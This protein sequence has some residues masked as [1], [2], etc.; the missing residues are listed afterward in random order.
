MERVMR[1]IEVK[2]SVDINKHASNEEIQRWLEFELNA[3]GNLSR[4]NPLIDEAIEA[5]SFSVEFEDY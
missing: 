4:T 1:T 5:N 2:F 3:N